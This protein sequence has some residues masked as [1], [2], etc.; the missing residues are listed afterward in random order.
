MPA[1]FH[2]SSVESL[3]KNQPFGNDGHL[4]C[5]CW[6]VVDGLGCIAA[7]AQASNMP[8]LGKQLIFGFG[9]SSGFFML[10]A[11]VVQPKCVNMNSISMSS[12]T[13]TGWETTLQNLAGLMKWISEQHHLAGTH[14]VQN[15]HELFGT[16]NVALPLGI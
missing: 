9:V 5:Q 11:N 2:I 6:V 12:P 7:Q 1:K 16:E 10:L 8:M 13:I 4:S 14:L 3:E 15:C